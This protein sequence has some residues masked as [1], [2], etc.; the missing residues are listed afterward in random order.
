MGENK[1]AN[2]GAMP[3]SPVRAIRQLGTA[4]ESR[5]L[6]RTE[7]TVPQSRCK[8]VFVIPRCRYDNVR[9]VHK[10]ARSLQ[11]AG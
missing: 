5:E 8:V 3:V 6:A 1:L 4:I 9:A 11:Q 10:Q 2:T 7:V